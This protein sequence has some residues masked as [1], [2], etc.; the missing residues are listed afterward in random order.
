[1]INLGREVSENDLGLLMDAGS[2]L[3]MDLNRDMDTAQTCAATAWGLHHEEP[4]VHARSC[5]RWWLTASPDDDLITGMI[6]V[7]AL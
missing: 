3:G 4:R 5:G 2:Y 7:W 6:Y 1:M